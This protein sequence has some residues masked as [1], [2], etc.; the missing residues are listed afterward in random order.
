M[1]TVPDIFAG[2]KLRVY[3]KTGRIH[4]H[5][6]HNQWIFGTLLIKWSDAVRTP[7]QTNWGDHNQFRTHRNQCTRPVNLIRWRTGPSRCK[8]S[9]R[10][11]YAHKWL[12]CVD[13]CVRMLIVCWPIRLFIAS[14]TMAGNAFCWTSIDQILSVCGR[15]TRLLYGKSCFHIAVFTP[16]LN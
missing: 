14:N 3:E 16:P 1:L 10:I 6:I 4:F 11:W 5:V 2:S 12:K 15:V 13:P 7:L 9:A 8:E